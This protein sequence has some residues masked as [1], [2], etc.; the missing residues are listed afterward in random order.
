MSN[1]VRAVV[2]SSPQSFASKQPVKQTLSSIAAGAWSDFK[3]TNKQSAGK[4][5]KLAA[6]LIV[7]G[8]VAQEIGTLTPIQWIMRGFGALPLE[9]TKS[10]AIQ[11]FEYSGLARLEMVTVTTATKF[12]LV[13]IAFETGVAVGSVFN[14]FLSDQTKDAIGGTINEIVNEQGWKLLFRHPF[15]IGM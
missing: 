12:A 7:G 10:G 2:Y 11:V 13:T 4:A 5:A 8:T 1:R 14:Q 15:C 9:F 3:T 6:S